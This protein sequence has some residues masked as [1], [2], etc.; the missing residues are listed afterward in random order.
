MIYHDP[1]VTMLR[2]RNGRSPHHSSI[3]KINPVK[4]NEVSALIRRRFG[5]SS[6]CVSEWKQPQTALIWL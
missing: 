3:K 2:I 4:G 5:R 6:Q 1:F